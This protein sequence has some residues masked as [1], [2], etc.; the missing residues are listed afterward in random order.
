M[1][2]TQKRTIRYSESF[3]LQIIRCIEEEGLSISTVKQRY[4]IKGDQ[5]IQT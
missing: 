3:K 5:T 1:H 4:S 2:T